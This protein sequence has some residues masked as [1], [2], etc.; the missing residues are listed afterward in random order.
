MNISLIGKPIV[1]LPSFPLYF[2]PLLN[3][4][5][6][7]CLCMLIL[8]SKLISAP[9]MM[10]YC[11]IASDVCDENI[12]DYALFIDQDAVDLALETALEAAL[13]SY[14]GCEL[15]IEDCQ[16]YDVYVKVKG[17]D[18]GNNKGRQNNKFSNEVEESDPVAVFYGCPSLVE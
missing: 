18:P 4:G 6:I 9:A 7:A 13:E 12:K 10:M 15:D 2:M 17:L 14:E 5:M 1:I 11:F 3:V 16:E 8:S